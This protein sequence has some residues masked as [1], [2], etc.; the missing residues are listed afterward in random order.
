MNADWLHPDW[1]DRR[2]FMT[3]QAGDASREQIALELGATPV[4]LHQV[5][6]A[7]VVNLTSALLSGEAPKAD[8]SV[9]TDPA[10]ACVVRVADCLPVL[11]SAPS[12]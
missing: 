7:A 3:T 9:S 10:L 2:A 12:G 6:G 8:A 5:H 11:F 4:F 1:P